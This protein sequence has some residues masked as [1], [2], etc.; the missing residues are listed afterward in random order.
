MVSSSPR[1]LT[2]MLPPSSTTW[3]FSP[4]GFTISGG[5]T[6]CSTAAAARFGSG[7]WLSRCQLRYF[8][9]PL[10]SPVCNRHLA[11]C[12]AHENRSRSRAASRDWSA[13]D[14]SADWPAALRRAQARG[15]IRVRLARRLRPLVLDDDF[16]AANA[17]K[18]PHDLR[19][20]KR[21]RRRT[22]R[23]SRCGYAASP[24]TWPPSAP[25]RPACDSRAIAGSMQFRV[26]SFKFRLV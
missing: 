18:L 25:I 21:N 22:C 12:V 8:A 6:S 16:D 23:A 14:G 13:S 24:A 19:V 10:K 2:S 4:S 11:A 1:P 9:Q 17:R 26:S 15:Q 5:R 20:D 3:R 7:S